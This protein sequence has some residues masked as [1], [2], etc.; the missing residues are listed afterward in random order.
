M[1]NFGNGTIGSTPWW[2]AA[3]GYGYGDRSF[4]G[5]GSNAVRINRN[6]DITR[7]GIDRISDQNPAECSL[8]R[9]LR[10][11][12]GRIPG[13]TADGIFSPWWPVR[14]GDQFLAANLLGGCTFR[15]PIPYGRMG[16]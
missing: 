2:S 5:D 11:S 3:A 6:A 7:L 1:D 15:P 13:L 9:Q 10:D 4:A 16:R 12:L 14:P 8:D